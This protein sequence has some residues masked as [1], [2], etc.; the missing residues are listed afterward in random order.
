MYFNKNLLH[1]HIYM[2]MNLIYNID[3]YSNENSNQLSVQK[4]AKKQ[5]IYQI[6]L[7]TLA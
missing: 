4:L 3:K 1:I 6:A 7:D 5:L 2:S